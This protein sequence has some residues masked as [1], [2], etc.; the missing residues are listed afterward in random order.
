MLERPR[1]QQQEG[2]RV[3]YLSFLLRIWRMPHDE[4][5]CR[6]DGEPCRGTDRPG[7]RASLE[8]PN[9][10]ER[11]GFGSLE[12]LFSF[13]RAQ[14]GLAP[15]VSGDQEVGGREEKEIEETTASGGCD[16]LMGRPT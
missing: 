1:P 2:E 5:A 4:N 13:L 7:W 16:P 6:S 9:T 10:G 12:D 11:L 3:D 15:A 8:R 14:V